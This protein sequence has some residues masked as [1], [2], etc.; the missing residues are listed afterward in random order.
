MSGDQINGINFHRLGLEVTR[1]VFQGLIGDRCPVPLWD[2]GVKEVAAAKLAELGITDKPTSFVEIA[3]HVGVL[4]PD[5]NVIDV[6]VVNPR[7]KR[8]TRRLR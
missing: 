2:G 8:R 4:G 7:R 5:P 6:E 1:L 3:R